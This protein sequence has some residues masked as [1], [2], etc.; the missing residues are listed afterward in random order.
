MSLLITNRCIN[1]DMCEPECPNKAI[2]MGKEFY[3]INSK[4]C[5]ECIGHY[6]QPTCQSVC[7]IK[8]AIK[9]DPNN[10]ENKKELWEKFIILKNIENS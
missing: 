1:C 8:N 2:S 6:D 4:L 9:K 5:T 3:K 7:P 10:I